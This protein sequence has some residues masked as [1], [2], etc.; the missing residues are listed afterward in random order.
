MGSWL[1]EGRR[2]RRNSGTVICETEEPLQAK[3]EV[4]DGAV[5]HRGDEGQLWDQLRKEKAAGGY[6]WTHLHHNEDEEVW[7]NPLKLPVDI[8]RETCR[9]KDGSIPAEWFHLPTGAETPSVEELLRE[10]SPES[11][12]EPELLHVHHPEVQL[13]ERGRDPGHKT[14]CGR[15]TPSGWRTPICGKHRH[16]HKSSAGSSP[17]PS[18]KSQY[19][20]TS[21]LRSQHQKNASQPDRKEQ[22]EPENKETGGYEP[23]GERLLQPDANKTQI[24]R[25]PS[26]KLPTL[27]SQ[28]GDDSDTIDSCF[29]IKKSRSRS[30]E[31]K[32]KKSS[33]AR[34]SPSRDS[35]CSEHAYETPKLLQKSP[36]LSAPEVDR[37]IEPGVRKKLKRTD[38]EDGYEPVG[39][40][41]SNIKK[42][43][44][45]NEETSREADQ[46]NEVRN[47]EKRHHESKALDQQI[48][49][50]TFSEETINQL[51]QYNEHL[52]D[53]STVLHLQRN[54]I[55]TSSKT[56]STAVNLTKK[57]K[58][59][60]KKRKAEEEKI[61]KEEKKKEMLQKKAQEQEEKQRE[62]ARKIEEKIQKDQ[63]KKQKKEEEK[64]LK[65]KKQSLEQESNTTDDKPQYNDE[66]KSLIDT[67]INKVRKQSKDEI[68]NNGKE[69]KCLEIKEY[70]MQ[71]NIDKEMEEMQ[72]LTK[73]EQIAEKEITQKIEEREM[74][75]EKQSKKEEREKAKQ[76]KEEERRKE[77]LAKENEKKIKEDEKRRDEEAKEIERQR[78]KQAREEEK[79]KKRALKD[80]EEE[81]KRQR[82]KEKR[83]E[84]AK[85]AKEKRRKGK[86]KR[87]RKKKRKTSKRK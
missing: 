87:R 29:P 63:E 20:S 48:K 27:P 38:L 78:E 50:S 24:S 21:S 58:K 34:R 56:Q 14:P 69:N 49:T 28:D 85:Q 23:V 30:K 5:E 74:I 36:R 10:S 17:A 37:S 65:H 75:K 31:R 45:S 25:S 32:E 83:D 81:K 47:I 60:L 86:S 66:N 80:L 44:N 41:N 61:K 79:L 64:A 11:D 62:K 73:V 6:P 76:A 15:K 42:I 12:V 33:L 16:R 22:V 43:V 4:M 84:K 26:S 68:T 82:E 55:S 59:E 67:I 77:R 40:P 46:D 53:D 7:L 2:A 18:L 1:P 35:G 51:A 39:K 13:E 57:Q 54:D 70:P 8:S 71:D 9:R 72:T 3:Q 52:S 19:Q